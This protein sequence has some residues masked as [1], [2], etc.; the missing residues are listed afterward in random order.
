MPWSL[1]EWPSEWG[2][3]PSDASP[4][5][6]VLKAKSIGVVPAVADHIPDA[7]PPSTGIALTAVSVVPSLA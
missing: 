3:T 6:D 4:L 7:E 5:V 1:L 2:R